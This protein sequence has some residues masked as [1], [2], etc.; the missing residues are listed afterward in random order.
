MK[1]KIQKIMKGTLLGKAEV[2]LRTDA[3]DVTIK[4]ICLFDNHGDIS[5]SMPKQA[6]ED[7]SGEK[8]KRQIVVYDDNAYQKVLEEVKDAWKKSS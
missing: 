3:G 4:E 7:R 6:Y 5:V 2:T 8:K 1:V